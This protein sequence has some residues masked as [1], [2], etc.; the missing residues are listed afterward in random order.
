[1][2]S[3]SCLHCGV[4]ISDKRKDQSFCSRDCFGASISKNPNLNHSF[5]SIQTPISSY[6]AGFIAADGWI[7]ER[8][9]GQDRISIT[10]S[11]RDRE[12]LERLGSTIGATTINDFTSMSYGKMRAFSRIDFVSDELSSSLASHFNIT[13]R[14]SL[15]LQPPELS[16]E[17][18]RLA[19]I[20][21]YIDGDGSYAIDYTQNKPKL[22][23]IGTRAM[24]EYI[25]ANLG[26]KSKIRV[27][28]DQFEI[29]YNNSNAVMA[30]ER[31]IHMELPF[32]RSKYKRWELLGVD[33]GVFFSKEITHG[34]QH[35]YPHVFCRCNECAPKRKIYLESLEK[36]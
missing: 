1:M 5:F 13:P 29:L 16:D 26:C 14:K 20:A 7:Q 3:R 32:L 23:A 11:R 15:T 12:H 8:G 25:D 19:F 34:K 35:E 28:G 27:K 17:Q 2:T 22:I 24:C 31:Y 9:R 18:C 33:V 36:K 4:D 21:G 6:W 30:R 10:L